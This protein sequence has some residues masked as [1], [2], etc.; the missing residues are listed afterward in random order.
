MVVMESID[1]A[2]LALRFLGMQDYLQKSNL[3]SWMFAVRFIVV[4]AV[5]IIASDVSFFIIAFSPHDY[6]TVVQIVGHL[7][8]CSAHLLVLCQFLL[9]TEILQ[10]RFEMLHQLLLRMRARR[11]SPTLSTFVKDV[12]I[13]R[14]ITELHHRL[15]DISRKVNV[16]YS[17]PLFARLTVSFISLLGT[18]YAAV[19]LAMFTQF[20]QQ[21][22]GLNQLSIFTVSF[23]EAFTIVH[24]TSRL[25]SKVCISYRFIYEV[26]RYDKMAVVS[27]SMSKMMRFEF[28]AEIVSKIPSNSCRFCPVPCTLSSGITEH[29]KNK[30][31]VLLNWP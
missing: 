20:A 17:L 4:V 10:W 18:G 9:W 2:D 13:I 29:W 7:L 3:K 16:I 28:S 15:I 23:L 22:I 5:I 6:S 1:K 31:V 25:C 24:C 19:F 8:T 21:H 14:N 11:M 27:A 12:Q 30:F 26:C